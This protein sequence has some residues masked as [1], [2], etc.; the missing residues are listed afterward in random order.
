VLVQKQMRDFRMW[1][2]GGLLPDFLGIVFLLFI[3]FVSHPAKAISVQETGT[4]ELDY[5][6]YASAWADLNNDGYLDYIAINRY[7]N[8]LSVVLGS[9][10]GN[11]IVGVQYATGEE[12]KAVATGDFNGDGYADIAV[13]NYSGNSVSLYVN[14]G[15]GAFSGKVDYSGGSRSKMVT[16]C[17][18]NNDDKLDIIVSDYFGQGI[19]VLINSGAGKL[20]SQI[21]TSVTPPTR[22]VCADF[23]ND[24]IADVAINDQPNDAVSILASI[25]DGSFDVIDSPRVMNGGGVISATDINKDGY[26]DLVSVNP[27]KVSVITNDGNGNFRSTVVHDT[28]Y[29]PSAVVNADIDADGYQDIL[30]SNTGGISI[31]FNNH[32]G[33]FYE[34]VYYANDNIRSPTDVLTIDVNNDGLLDMAVGGVV[35]SNISDG[36]FSSVSHYTTGVSPESISYGDFNN[37][38][39]TDLGVANLHSGNVAVLLNDEESHFPTKYSYS[40]G[41]LPRSVISADVNNDNKLDLVVA[42]SGNDVVSVLPNE[43]DSV[44]SQQTDY[45]AGIDP[46]SVVAVD[47][48]N[49]GYV[50]LAA[51]NH[52]FQ[53]ISVSVFINDKRGSFL[54]GAK[55][56]TSSTP[57][58][59]TTGDFDNNG[60]DDLVVD[61][62]AGVVIM[63]NYGTGYFSGPAGLFDGDFPVMDDFN[64]DGLVD[65][66]TTS[67]VRLNTMSLERRVIDI[68]FSSVVNDLVSADFNN[69]GYI[70]MAAISNGG[71]SVFNN[72]GGA[73]FDKPV[74]HLYR[75]VPA[76]IVSTDIN[77]DG[78]KDLVTTNK[79][80]NYISVMLNQLGSPDQTS[81]AGRARSSGSSANG[82]A[83]LSYAL[84]L[85][86]GIEVCRRLGG[87]RKR[88]E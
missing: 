53:D 25:G 9:E 5:L 86:L 2:R 52:Y 29:V 17:D 14:N 20:D 27:Y 84:L 55:I 49:D 88:Y 36:Q 63:Y 4:F 74:T 37:D 57:S 47:A 34:S 85:L 58:E 8:Y 78:Y 42:Y 6:A 19:T 79:D 44:F 40:A 43:G 35:L 46:Y 7:Q 75:S 39:Y 3:V 67:G 82:V 21:T 41:S 80:K 28:P 62:S 33:R 31:L 45:P 71:V 23:N 65:I 30:I 77:G 24:G 38:G 1:L 60:F 72:I 18:V 61:T 83:S 22:A 66:A 76:S 10:T 70:D 50:D 11:S 15:H 48:N 13:A 26:L 81:A 69:D 87:A 59:V 56:P 68:P 51:V 12:P 64:N 73:G 54:S 32:E 16:P